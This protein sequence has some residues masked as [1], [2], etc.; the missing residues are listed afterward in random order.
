MKTSNFVFEAKFNLQSLGIKTDDTSKL[1][2]NY[3]KES[4][5]D[6]LFRLKNL[7]D[8]FMVYFYF[9]FLCDHWGK[10]EKAMESHKWAETYCDAKIGISRV[11]T[12]YDNLSFATTMFSSK[13]EIYSLDE[14]GKITI[15]VADDKKK[16]DES[17][18]LVNG[19]NGVS[20]IHDKNYVSKLYDPRLADTSKALALT[21]LV[22]LDVE[23]GKFISFVIFDEDNIKK[24]DFYKNN[25]KALGNAKDQI[26]EALKETAKIQAMRAM[27]MALIHLAT[28][29]TL[30][31]IR[32]ANTTRM[33]T[34]NIF[35][36]F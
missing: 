14:N 7:G 29:N 10:I 15:V 35:R 25:L 13:P 6:T 8:A 26:N 2:F 20:Y 34:M 17:T 18:V 21:S 1:T 16:D 32:M 12:K 31:M 9:K 23:H 30:R 33:M 36:R 28:M 24:S 3:V 4:V 11:K 5:L 22:N 19:L 27:N